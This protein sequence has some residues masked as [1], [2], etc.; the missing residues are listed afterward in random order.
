MTASTAQI[1]A[2]LA[3]AHDLRP[4]TDTQLLEYVDLCM[5]FRLDRAAVCPGHVA[6]AQLVADAFFDR[7][8]SAVAVGPRSGGK[9][10]ALSV[11]DHMNSRFRAGCFTTHVGA[12][13]R[14]ASLG[15]GY[16]LEY[17]KLPHYANDVA[18]EPTQIRTLYRNGSE[19]AILPGTLSGVSGPHPSR[20]VLDEAD[21]TPWEVY[22][23]FLGMPMSKVGPDGV[24]IPQQ[25]LITSALRTSF[26]VMNRIVREA[27]G[28]KRIYQWCALETLEGCRTC[29][30]ADSA[31]RGIALEPPHCPLW[32]QCGGRA[33]RARGH[34]PLADLLHRFAEVDPQTWAIQYRLEE[35]TGE[36]LVVPTW[37]DENVSEEAEYKRGAGP[38]F[39]CWDYGFSDP[40]VLYWCQ[41][42]PNRDIN[43]FDGIYTSGKAIDEVLD[44][45]HDRSRPEGARFFVRD[46]KTGVERGP[47]AKPVRSW[48]DAAAPEVGHQIRKRCG[49]E[50]LTRPMKVL[51]SVSVLRFYVRDNTGRR[52]L[53]VHPRV[54]GL[55]E[56]MPGWH[57]KQNPNGTFD[58]LPA[59][60]HGGSNPD[61]AIDAVRYALYHIEQGGLP[62]GLDYIGIVGEPRDD[63]PEW[64]RERRGERRAPQQGGPDP[65]AAAQRAPAGRAEED[66]W[67]LCG[68]W[69]AL[70]P[71]AAAQPYPSWTGRRT[72]WNVTAPERRA[73]VHGDHTGHPGERVDRAG[74][75]VRA[76]CVE[77]ERPGEARLQDAERT[78]R[79]ERS[80]VEARR[81]RVDGD[82]RLFR[83]DVVDAAAA[84]VCDDL[85]AGRKLVRS[86]EDDV[87]EVAVV[88]LEDDG[89]ARL[90][91]ERRPHVGRDLADVRRQS[92]GDVVDRGAGGRGRHARS[93]T[94]V[95]Q[96]ALL[97]VEV[98][99]EVG[100]A[101]GLDRLRRIDGGIRRV[102]AHGAAHRERVD[103]ADVLVR[104]R[105]REGQAVGRSVRDADEPGVRVR[106]VAGE[107]VLGGGAVGGVRIEDLLLRIG[108]V[109]E[110][111]VLEDLRQLPRRR[112]GDGVALESL[113][114][115]LDGVALADADIGGHVHLDVE[116]AL[117]VAGEHLEGGMASGRCG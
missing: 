78:G 80:R 26:G 37:S 16:M 114:R 77:A 25:T 92:D 105:L 12:V 27:R 56:E 61:H 91:V 46:P 71:A 50:D 47:Y 34:V 68:D 88:V 17:L 54:Y 74:V 117:G 113:R 33:R 14:Q 65:H 66:R 99:C 5:G 40:F 22:Q 87:V 39:W 9:T 62:T 57:R 107:D 44:L 106:T 76:R 112:E 79:E 98:A 51:D 69:Q 19:V 85:D 116:S 95:L 111:V 35:G 11:L 103:E 67:K 96:R 23:Q 10:R 6:P 115:P 110:Q 28:T 1:R 72:L 109:V 60:N 8:T 38:T 93:I 108:G 84:G 21:F 30:D 36:G 13:Q 81:R 86:F 100:L 18:T 52:R 3:A 53:K 104:S 73:L 42:M 7:F 90:D 75:L 63:Q 4:H 43:V 70:P 2:A 24:E 20:A 89:V 45:V 64:M 83:D 94:R 32:T 48:G 59:E 31:G 29:P 58:E 102:D 41:L 49:V 15:Y 55:K 82:R 97:D 101:A